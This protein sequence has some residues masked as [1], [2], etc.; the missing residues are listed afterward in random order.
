MVWLHHFFKTNKM[1]KFS[2][3]IIIVFGLLLTIALISNSETPEQ[4]KERWKQEKISRNIKRITSGLST[5]ANDMA[6]Q[7]ARYPLSVKYVDYDL[8][9]YSFTYTF[10]RENAFKQT[11]TGY[12]IMGINTN[13]EKG[14]FII[15]S[16]TIK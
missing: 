10:T 6:I 14:T 3:L 15:N 9:P 11:S 1:T 8:T 4:Q 16:K 7:S 13:T 5:I 2:K 12:V